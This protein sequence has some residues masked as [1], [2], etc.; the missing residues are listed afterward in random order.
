MCGIC[1]FCHEFGHVLGLDDMY[2]TNNNYTYNTLSFWDIMDSGPYLNFGRTPCGYSAYERFFLNWMIPTELKTAGN[3]SLDTLATS[4]TAFLISQAGN[5][6]LTLANDPTSPEYFLLENRQRKGW[7]SYLPG[8][9]MLATHIYYDASTWLSNTPNND[10]KAMGVDII[11]ADGVAS[12]ATLSVDPFPGTK[13]ITL[14]N[15]LIRGN[16]DILKPL[17]NIKETSGVITF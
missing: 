16:I 2:N 5:H 13:N 9:G 14:F 17:K 10:P 3:Y 4:N 12:D 11:E 6:N 1:T 15:P 7:D 8:H